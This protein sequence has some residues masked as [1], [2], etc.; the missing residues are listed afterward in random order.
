[1][2]K[3]NKQN[4]SEQEALR[5]I[6]SDQQQEIPKV[7]SK[8]DDPCYIAQADLLNRQR[9]TN[10]LDLKTAS[11]IVSEQKNWLYPN[12]LLEGELTILAGSPN[13]GKT[14]LACAL[15]AGI[16]NGT[17]YSLYPNF[18]PSGEGHVIIVNR[19]DDEANGLKVRLQA[20]EAN[21]DMVHFIG[22]KAGPGD[23]SPFSFSNDRDINR[24]IGL[25]EQL[26][27]LIGLIIVDP[28]YFA[29]DGDQNSDHKAR[30]AYQKLTMLAKRI[31]CAILGIAHTARNTMG[32]SALARIAGPSALRQVP[33]QIL[34]L[35]K[36]V[37]GP[38]ESG[39]THVLVQAKNSEGSMD[40]GFEYRITPVE[41]HVQ[42]GV[43]ETPKFVIT[44]R[45]SSSAEEILEMADRG[46][47]DK[48]IR[49]LDSAVQFLRALLKD[50]P[51]LWIEIEQLAKDAN[52]K[53]ATLM[54]AKTSLKIVAVKVI[55]NKGR[56]QWCL[57]D[58]FDTNNPST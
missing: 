10:K 34:L 24:L 37:N 15:A 44:R 47:T 11:N 53:K 41:I 14:T 6:Q 4:I 52:I 9:E 5:L 26:N 7:F 3:S 57:P 43:I 50:G 8:W 46:V 12:V 40:G 22:G 39:G 27:G 48:K 29:V 30:K 31:R 2:F 20:A 42:G 36:I 45:I 58:D 21:L 13:A 49:K 28:V 54:I 16:T 18:T 51:R 32:K 25:S 35:S 19:E 55:G 23:D 56:S 33:R 38:T 1:M 17:N